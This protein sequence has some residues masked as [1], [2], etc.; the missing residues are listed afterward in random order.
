MNTRCPLDRGDASVFILRLAPLAVGWSNRLL[1]HGAFRLVEGGG[2][3]TPLYTI[4]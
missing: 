4:P 3:V 2:Q 1:P